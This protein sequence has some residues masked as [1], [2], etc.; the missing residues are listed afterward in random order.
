MK[1][2]TEMAWEPLPAGEQDQTPPAEHRC[3]LC[4]EVCDAG[5]FH[6]KCADRENF[7]AE[8]GERDS[9]D[10]SPIHRERHA[11]SAERSEAA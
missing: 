10:E 4:G 11:H 2:N 6:S 7:Y 8:V 9:F 3:T 1:G 5:W